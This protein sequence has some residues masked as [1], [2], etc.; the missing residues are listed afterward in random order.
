MPCKF[1]YSTIIQKYKNNII[2][3]NCVTAWKCIAEGRKCSL[4]QALKWKTL[5]KSESKILVFKYLFLFFINEWYIVWY[6]L[7]LL[8]HLDLPEYH[9]KHKT[10][11]SLLYIRPLRSP[12]NLLGRRSTSSE[13][14]SISLL[15][16]MLPKPFIRL[17]W[18]FVLERYLR[19]MWEV[20]GGA[21]VSSPKQTHSGILNSVETAPQ[22]IR[23]IGKIYSYKPN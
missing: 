14:A 9:H 18:N 2:D 8:F 17:N 15:H 3:P 12:P 4:I 21:L 16:R 19:G 13:D 1:N 10:E 6:V 7:L 23:S 11:F 20:K 5:R 22:R